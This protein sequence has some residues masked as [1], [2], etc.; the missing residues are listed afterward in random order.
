VEIDNRT[1][2]SPNYDSR[3][4]GIEGICLH[5]TEGNFPHDAGW[6]CNPQSRVSAHYVISRDGRVFSLV[7]DDKRAWHAGHRWGNDA[8][9]GIEISHIAGQDYPV[10]QLQACAMLCVKLIQRYNIPHTGI[11][12]HRWLT[13]ARKSD[14]TDMTDEELNYWIAELY[15]F[16]G[17]NIPIEHIRPSDGWYCCKYPATVRTAPGVSEGAIVATFAIDSYV[18]VTWVEGQG[19]RGSH[20]WAH[21]TESQMGFIHASA[22]EPVE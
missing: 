11:V 6:L 21:L 1:Y 3:P 13:P 14:P 22:L 15:S 12:A 20:W 5:T 16:R 8:T 9:I 18:L 10:E 7:D 17:G 19:V 2:R 4:G